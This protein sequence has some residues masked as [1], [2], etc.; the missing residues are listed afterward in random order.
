MLKGVQVGMPNSLV[1]SLRVINILKIN[2]MSNLR[3]FYEKQLA[4]KH[5]ELA[6]IEQQI[7]TSLNSVDEGK[8]IKSGEQVLLTISELDE[9]L[10]AI[11][12]KEKSETFSI[13]DFK[14][15]LRK[16]DFQEARGIAQ[17]LHT[18]FQNQELGMAV[19]LLQK[20][21]KQMGEYCLDEMLSTIFKSNIQNVFLKAK[22]G[23]NYV[24]H[25]VGGDDVYEKTALGFLRKISESNGIEVAENLLTLNQAVRRLFCSSLRSGDCLLILIKDFHVT[26]DS[27]GFVDFATWFL[28]DFWKLLIDEIQKEVLPKYGRIKVIAVLTSSSMIDEA[29]LKSLDFGNIN[30][31]NPYQLLDIPLPD[32]NKSDI[33]SW[34]I[35]FQRMERCDSQKKAQSAYDGS[36][37]TPQTI[38]STL[39]EMAYGQLI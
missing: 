27:Q 32:W 24:S 2:N 28:Q 15:T 29:Y 39:Q 6:K 30:K 10:A 22:D 31:F 37:G 17:K 12:T 25:I 18:Q 3:N 1:N 21:R 9:K 26:D 16:I 23:G 38:C 8:L 13:T 33:E 36:D 19:F 35:E 14:S 34:L 7:E 20:S 4:R 5:Q 11:G